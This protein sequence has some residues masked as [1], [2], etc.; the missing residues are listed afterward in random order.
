MTPASQAGEG[1]WVLGE[2]WLPSAR[3]S[4]SGVEMAAREVTLQE[5]SESTGGFNVY[6]A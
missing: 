6:G 4:G 1:I 5:V 3:G 2:S